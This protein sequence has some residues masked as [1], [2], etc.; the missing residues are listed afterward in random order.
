MLAGQGFASFGG[1]RS[2]AANHAMPCR[3]FAAASGSSSYPNHLPVAAS[4]KLQSPTGV[5]HMHVAAAERV[6]PSTRPPVLPRS[7][8][9]SVLLSAL[10]VH[11]RPEL[12]VP[13]WSCSRELCC[14]RWHL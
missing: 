2:E 9:V 10:A 8:S 11:S 7:P 13:A 6:R 3:A 5:R 12:E 14:G 1:P 4:S